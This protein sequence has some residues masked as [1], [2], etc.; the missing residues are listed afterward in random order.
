MAPSSYVRCERDVGGS[1]SFCGRPICD[2]HGWMGGPF[3]TY[4][5]KR[6]SLKDIIRVILD[7]YVAVHRVEKEGQDVLAAPEGLVEEI[8]RAMMVDP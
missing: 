3:N 5:C 6:H 4:F 1:C 8:F 7:V 2:D